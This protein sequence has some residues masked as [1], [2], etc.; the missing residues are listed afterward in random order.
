MCFWMLLI[1]PIV[2]IY[3]IS[4]LRSKK[5]KKQRIIG[6]LLVFL[7]ISFSLINIFIV[8]LIR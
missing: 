8:A 7:S 3:G 2:F 4:L 5:S 6:G 1:L